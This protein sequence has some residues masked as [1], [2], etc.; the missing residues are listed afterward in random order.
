MSNRESKNCDQ[1]V[2]V[3]VFK[4][5][6]VDLTILDRSYSDCSIGKVIIYRLDTHPLGSGLSTSLSLSLSPAFFDRHRVTRKDNIAWVIGY[7]KKKSLILEKETKPL[8][9]NVLQHC[10]ILRYA[11]AEKR[12][13]NLQI[14]RIAFHIQTKLSICTFS[15]SFAIY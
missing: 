1:E 11:Q 7:K 13:T 14:N 5:Q 2:S 9:T 15:F 6:F 8:R 12:S 10:R 3:R 4:C